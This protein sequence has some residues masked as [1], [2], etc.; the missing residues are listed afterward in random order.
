MSITKTAETI[1]KGDI[2]CSEYGDYD[3]WCNFVFVSCEP[4]G[5]NWTKINVH[6]VGDDKVYSIYD[7]RNINKVTFEV[8]GKILLDES[9]K[10]NII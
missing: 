9:V 4:D 10:M 7:G 1:Q 8:V 3:N 6:N 5:E 2:F